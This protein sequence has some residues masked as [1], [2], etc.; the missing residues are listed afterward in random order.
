[1]RLRREDGVVAK[2]G[3]MPVYLYASASGRR[4]E[5]CAYACDARVSFNFNGARASVDRGVWTC[6]LYVDGL[7]R[8]V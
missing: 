6:C 8:R 1:M 5:V 2:E 7:R 4:G 3:G